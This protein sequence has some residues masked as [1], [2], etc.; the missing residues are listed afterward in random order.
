MLLENIP[1]RRKVMTVILVTSGAVLLLTCAA[2]FAYEFVTFR[3]ASIR[4][5]STISQIVAANST[6]ALAFDDRAA[7]NE[8]LR[9]LRAERHIV[10]A[11]LYDHDGRLF[12]YY[13]ASLSPDELP[14]TAGR[15]GFRFERS[16]LSGFQPVEQGDRRLG[17]LYLRTDMGAMYQRF[18]L[19]GIIALLVTGVSLILAYLLSRSLQ[20]Q[21]SRPILALAGTARVVSDRRDY[22]VRATKLGE[23]EVGSLT[24]AFN[25]MLTRIQEQ[26][27]RLDLLNRITHGIGERQHLASIFQVVL[28]SLEEH[29]P[30][31]FGLVCLYD[32][33][34]EVLTVSSIGAESRPLAVK[35]G[36]TDETHLPIDP[37]GLARCVRG[38]LVYEPD[39]SQ[40]SF[41]FPQRL[42]G[43]G[44]RSV[45][46]A[47]LAVED[48][49]FGVLIASRRAVGAFSSPDCEFLRQLSEHVALAAH[50]AK[51]HAALQTAFDD[52]RQTQQAVMQQE[53]LRA[54][55]QMASG[56]AHDINNAISPV[57]LYTESL[58]DNEP[59]LSARARDYLETIQHAVED[60][61]ETVARMREFYRQREEQVKLAPVDLNR[62]VSQVVDLTRARWSDM[63]QQRG[64]VIEMQ[65]EPAPDLPAILGVESEIRAALTNL[66]FNA[67]DA[68]PEGGTLT[69]RTSAPA[70]DP[71]AEGVASVPHVQIEVADTGVGM[72]E[73]TGR[74]CLEPFYT[75]KGDRGTGLGLAMVYG[76]AQRHGAEINI[77]STVGEG[78]TVRLLFPVPV[79]TTD[80]Q[81]PSDAAY[82]VPWRLRIL[83]VDDDPL[84]LK[85]LCDTLE[86]EGHVVVTANSGQAGIDAFRDAKANGKPFSAVITDLGMPYM[87]GREV[88]RIIKEISAAT[89]VIMLTGW[90]RRLKDDGEA[91]SHVDRVLS[92]PPR[93][94]E[95]RETLADCCRRLAS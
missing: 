4:Q 20:Q 38:D 21:I 17:T 66:I 53:R 80:G 47:P 23:D 59:D 26:I 95:L 16:Y 22:S 10:A 54:L 83:V 70:A 7:A 39:I 60:V 64:A 31:D 45:V 68:M 46:M 72:D 71:D 79:A 77:A 61:A 84:L 41:P 52:L 89:P 55:V 19:Y 29:M 58:L 43:G 87:D 93:L 9:A 92:K 57:S 2:Y 69:L 51:L 35:L 67:V 33:E 30:I 37:G 11:G 15:Q 36:L 90:G 3:Q 5:L 1:I 44:L 28:K 62:L 74:R 65:V 8:I 82:P 86:G 24:D 18:R 49:V 76:M 94:R 56:I 81:A 85:S 48:N 78:T 32:A 63:P 91:V 12:A 75:T 50:Q 34:E 6:A 14:A 25:H 42:S 27:A 40:L 88:A 13:P 73:E